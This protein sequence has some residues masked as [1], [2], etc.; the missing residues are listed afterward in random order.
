MTKENMEQNSGVGD[1]KVR[2]DLDKK[3]EKKA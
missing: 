3:I 2:D 1:G